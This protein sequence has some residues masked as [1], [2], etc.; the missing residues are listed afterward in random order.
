MR[1]VAVLMKFW[2]SL[3]R[4]RGIDR[5]EQWFRQDRGHPHTNDSL[6]WLRER[7][8]DRLIIRKCEIEWAAHSPDL[9]PPYFYLWGYLKDNVYENNPQTIGELKAAIT[10]KI[11]ESHRRNVCES[12]TIFRDVCNYAFN[13][14][15]AIWSTF[16]K[17]H[18]NSMQTDSDG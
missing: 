18:K 2:G 7:F 8:K 12:L 4:R 17:E 15:D 1:Y 10:A 3:G 9:N 6:A 13:A 16:W 5:D 14:D 11:R